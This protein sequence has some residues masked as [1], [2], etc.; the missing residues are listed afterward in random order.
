MARRL[1]SDLAPRLV[2]TM[3]SVLALELNVASLRGDLPGGTDAERL[4][5]F[6]SRISQLEWF[7]D[8][9]TRYPVVPR[10]LVTAITDRVRAIDEALGRYRRDRRRLGAIGIGSAER[11]VG[12]EPGK[13]DPHR[14]G[15]TT[16]V[17]ETETGGRM[18]YKPRPGEADAAFARFTEWLNDNGFEPSLRS[19]RTV[20]AE[21]CQWQEFVRHRDCGEA[22][23]VRRFYRRQG[24]LM[25]LL[26]ALGT[27]DLHREN[28]MAVGDHPLLLDLET[29]FHVHHRPSRETSATYRAYSLVSDSVLATGL[30][31]FYLEDPDGR[32][33]SDLS[34]L[35]DSQGQLS[36]NAVLRW[37]EDGTTRMRGERVI[38]EMEATDNQPTLDGAPRPASEHVADIVEGFTGAYRIIEG[39]KEDFAAMMRG[40]ADVSVRHIVRATATYALAL[41]AGRHPDHLFN[42]LY[43]DRLFDRF[44]SGF[45]A[46]D[47]L[48]P[49]VRAERL[50]GSMLSRARDEA[51]R[52]AGRA[53]AV[54]ADLLEGAAGLVLVLLNAHET[55]EDDEL[56]AVAGEYGDAVLRAA[57]PQESG[58]GWATPVANLPLAGYAHG[59]AGIAHA[60]AALHSRT[61]EPRFAEAALAAVRYERS[62]YIEEAENWRDLR[63]ADVP[64]ED[65]PVAWCNGAPGI[66]AARRLM[67]AHLDVA[68]A[69]DE[70]FHAVNTTKR[71]GFERND[72]LC[73]GD[74]G[75]LE[76]LRLAGAPEYADRRLAASFVEAHRRGAWLSGWGHQRHETV[77]LFTGLAGTGLALLRG[78]F[79]ARVPWLEGPRGDRQW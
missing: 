41:E 13:S 64:V 61:G 2:A 27:S 18:V 32:K 22:E 79:G 59:A 14:G 36:P 54:S 9:T 16:L 56:L 74:L 40:C 37:A 24:G 17:F 69:A 75:N 7:T 57:E 35:G 12:I 4:D 43:R 63:E 62:L 60:L 52:L 58:I 20:C 5:H 72:C 23:G 29:L 30:L 55:V 1:A 39:R 3:Q 53:G 78:A 42:G 47:N 50:D 49:I 34:G 66:G 68:G 10:L 44:W 31:P 65:L 28:L 76:F 45:T 26:Y 67:S 25:A 70:V 73:H 71:R 51:M 33:G 77:G 38:V 48:A 21:R 8:A 11:I 46:A 6:R 19:P 15:R